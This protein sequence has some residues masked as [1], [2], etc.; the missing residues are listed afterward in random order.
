MKCREAVSDP[1]DG[2]LVC[3]AERGTEHSHADPALHLRPLRPD[4]AVALDD[5]D[6]LRVIELEDNDD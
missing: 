5:W 2:V 1:R 6:C 4:E 3:E